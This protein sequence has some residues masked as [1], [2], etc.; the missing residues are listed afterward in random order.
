MLSGA[1]TAGAQRSLAPRGEALAS[2]RNAP[3][4]R[5]S[6]AR[7]TPPAALAAPQAAAGPAAPR[8]AATRTRLG[9]SDLMVSSCTLGSMT[10]GHQNTEAEAHEQLDYAFEREFSCF[11]ELPIEAENSQPT[12]QSLSFTLLLLLQTA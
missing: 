11:L 7:A 12:N 10:W 1:L 5:R 2:L 9:S 3:A 6:S 4:A 8:S